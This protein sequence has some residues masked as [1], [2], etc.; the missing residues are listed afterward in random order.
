M[1]HRVMWHTFS[2]HPVLSYSSKRNFAWMKKSEKSKKKSIKKRRIWLKKMSRLFVFVLKPGYLFITSFEFIFGLRYKYYVLIN[3]CVRLNVI[4]IIR[5]N[6]SKLHCN[7]IWRILRSVWGHTVNHSSI[8]NIIFYYRIHV[9]VITYCIKCSIYSIYVGIGIGKRFSHHIFKELVF[10]WLS[11]W[12][13][14]Q[15]QQGQ[16]FQ[17]HYVLACFELKGF[18]YKYI[19]AAHSCYVFNQF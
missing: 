10:M 6:L 17:K 16:W 2:K 7:W 3:F 15:S 5:K 4:M 1:C 11:A 18:M 12:K 9:M 8:L 13:K 14:L 19:T